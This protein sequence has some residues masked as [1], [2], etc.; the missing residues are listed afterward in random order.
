MLPLPPIA[1]FGQTVIDRGTARFYAKLAPTGG[2][3]CVP[4]GIAA[5]VDPEQRDAFFVRRKQVR[6]FNMATSP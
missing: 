1:M 4:S 2:V 5:N 3:F 6:P